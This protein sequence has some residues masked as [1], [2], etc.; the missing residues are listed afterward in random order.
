MA[1]DADEIFIEVAVQRGFLAEGQVGELREALAGDE[2]SAPPGGLSQLARER[3]M[4]TVAQFVGVRRELR[5]QGIHAR[6]GGYEVISKLGQGGTATV[7]KARQTSLDRLVALKVLQP[8]RTDDASSIERFEREARL[9]ARVSHPNLIK[10][11]DVG[12]SGGRRF[13]AYRWCREPRRGRRPA[14]P[15]F[16][17]RPVPP[18]PVRRATS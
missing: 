16:R 9:A 12:H 6:I 5:R 1:P 4:L 11:Y 2:A 15:G 8:E 17:R 13:M 14:M 18:R 7:Y 10:V 3:G